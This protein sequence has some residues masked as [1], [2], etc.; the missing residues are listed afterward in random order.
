MRARYIKSHHSDRHCGA[1]RFGYLDPPRPSPNGLTRKHR[2]EVDKAFRPLRGQPCAIAVVLPGVQP[3]QLSTPKSFGK[4]LETTFLRSDSPLRVSCRTRICLWGVDFDPGVLYS[5]SNGPAAESGEL[6]LGNVGF[7]NLRPSPR[8]G[9]QTFED[10]TGFMSDGISQY[11]PFVQTAVDASGGLAA[12]PL[13]VAEGLQVG[14]GACHAGATGKTQ[15][16]E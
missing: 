16:I 2:G 12:A 13:T 1:P 10:A 3:G 8:G 15:T 14:N 7:S 4:D 5:C 11:F 6:H 9:V